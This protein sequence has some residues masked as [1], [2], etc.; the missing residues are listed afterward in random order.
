MLIA[1]VLIAGLAVIAKVMGT[2][3]KYLLNYWRLG[4][5][6]LLLSLPRIYIVLL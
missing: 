1:A 6:P 3:H 4:V 2:L 5:V